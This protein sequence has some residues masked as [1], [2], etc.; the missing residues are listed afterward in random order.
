VSYSQMRS[1]S[2][3]EAKAKGRD[4]KKINYCLIKLDRS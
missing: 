3:A 2:H 4:I 1:I